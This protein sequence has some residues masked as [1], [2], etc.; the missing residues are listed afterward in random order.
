MRKKMAR[1][2][3]Y[4][5]AAVLIFMAAV[6]PA[7]AGTGWSPPEMSRPNGQLV[8]Y[9]MSGGQ[10][11]EAGS[12]SYDEYLRE[13]AQDL[14]LPPPEGGR[15]L[16]IRLEKRG[17]GSAHLDSVFLGGLPPLS[18][19]AGGGPPLDKISQ[20]DFDLIDL[21]AGGL[22]LEFAAPEGSCVLSIAARIEGEVISRTPFQFPRENTFKEMDLNS[23][24]YSY[25]LNSLQGRINVDGS[26]NEIT[27]QD[28]FF[29]EFVYPISGHPPGAIYGWVMNDDQNLYVALDTTPDNTMDGDKDYAKVYVKTDSGLKEFKVSAPG[30][31]WGR[32]GFDYTS[33]VD[34]QHK[35]YE[36]A[37]PLT[38]LGAAGAANGELKLAFSAYGTMAAGWKRYNPSISH[39]VLNNKYLAV[40][41][42]Q[43]GYDFYVSGQILNADGTPLG[44]ELTVSGCNWLN[45]G[46]S[47]AGA[48]Y[49]GESSY[50]VTW[51]DNSI[52][53]GQ[54]IDAD[55][56]ATAGGKITISDLDANAYGTQSLAYDQVNNRFLVVWDDY[57]DA[58]K[59]I[60]GQLVN[61]DGTLAGGNF[62][63]CGNGSD[64]YEP[65]VSYGGGKYL[66][67]WRDMRN[68]VV[69]DIY[70]QMIN[71][72]GSLYPT[73][74]DT[75]T[76]FAVCSAGYN[77]ERP[78]AAFDSANERFLVAWQDYRNN[79]YDIYS[80]VV[81][82]D[83]TL[84]G[85]GIVVSNAPDSQQNHTV[86]YD[87]RLEKFLVAW[88]DQRNTYQE[89]YGQYIKPGSGPEGNN[90]PISDLE[91]MNQ[92]NPWAVYNP[93]AGEFI[94]A[95]TSGDVIAYKTM[96]ADLPPA[97]NF[98]AAVNYLVGGQ[99]YGI[100]A[101]DFN[102]DGKVDL[103]VTNSNAGGEENNSIYVLLGAGNGTFQEKV[104]YGDIYAPLWI[105]SGEFN[106]DGNTDLAVTSSDSPAL[107]V[108]A[109]AGDGSFPIASETGY[110]T[111]TS[112]NTVVTADFNHD[113]RLDL[114]VSNANSNSVSIYLYDSG[115]FGL[116]NGAFPRRSNADYPVGDGPIRMTVGDFNNDGNTDLAVINETGE[117][118][119]VL[120]GNGSGSFSAMPGEYSAGVDPI[121]IAAAD[122]NGD[123]YL[124]LA[125]A[126]FD[127]TFDFSGQ[128]TV[129]RGTGDGRFGPMTSLKVSDGPVAVVAGDFNGDG[130]ADLVVT[131]RYRNNVS[132]LAGNGKGFFSPA[133]N[134]N[135]DSSPM[136][137][138]SGDFNGDGWADLAVVNNGSA[139]VSILIN[140]LGPTDGDAVAADKADLTFADIRGSNTAENSI[141]SNLTLP[142]AGDRGTAISWSSSNQSCLSN[143]GAVTRPA[144]AQGDQMVT[145]T[146]TI[147][148]GG[149]SD[150]LSFSL[151]V[152]ALPQVLPKPQAESWWPGG[153]GMKYTVTIPANAVKDAAGN[154]LEQEYIFDF[155]TT[156]P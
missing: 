115:L 130:K 101:G 11:I 74:G 55:S 86:A 154:G 99:P 62:V 23:S 120:I 49:G 50:L 142:T 110:T 54:L 82:S 29:K 5:L 4:C 132:V 61:S 25:R 7:G 53:Y 59:D 111:G 118:V 114:A 123:G 35:V 105:T 107:V 96:A 41:N 45:S 149:V 138:T 14:A 46:P 68:G 117:T 147:S 90:F 84:S 98:Q 91:E 67:V 15:S 126:N 80:Q 134:L 85:D 155:T 153:A 16:K 48:V 21:P 17:G 75:V 58:S 19:D 1:T 151:T 13:G 92:V 83:G 87:S 112:A 64:Q 104:G 131:N 2:T 97:M 47:V 31:H 28:P 136:I 133:Q 156:G 33:K 106:N 20:K 63:I 77:Q 148:K 122:L 40:Y 6:S 9:I 124:D 60:Y 42:E 103:A 125:I 66:V 144:A 137:L 57:R 38:E 22:E 69:A 135:V 108:S 116:D 73:A 34:Y 27:G 150:T 12:L 127:V 39:D 70:G 3:L 43:D 76:N 8:I 10:W 18:S 89:I 139:K 121:G 152:K 37:I 36:F 146:A 93:A 30:T 145:L 52:I 88:D 119:S 79:N 26:I 100:T 140:G 141:T 65:A 32:P 51:E 113:G 81:N 24:F 143:A 95:Y 56:G 72:D 109:G 128:V 129:L 78:K 94:A 102:N 44:G 71:P